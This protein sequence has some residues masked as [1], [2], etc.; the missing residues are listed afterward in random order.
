MRVS[1]DKEGIRQAVRV[2]KEGGVAVFP[3]DT[4]YGIG[5]DPYNKRSVEEIY[6]IKSRDVSKSVPVLAY[7]EEIAEQIVDF[8]DATRRIIKRFWPGPLTVILKLTDKTMRE[9]LNLKDRI[10]IRVPDSK[11]ALELL[12]E[13]NFLVGTSANVSGDRPYTNPDECFKNLQGYDIFVDGGVIPSNTVSTIIE[14]K[15]DDDADDDARRIKVLREGA[16]S[17]EEIVELL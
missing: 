4:V 3:T 5:C 15:D 12:K 6:R 1:C 2:I 16:V 10:A 17:E 9:S 7:S 14:V 11:C 8:D 13:C